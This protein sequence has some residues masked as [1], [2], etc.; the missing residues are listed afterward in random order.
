MSQKLLLRIASFICVLVL[1]A[2][3]NAQSIPI[4]SRW[5]RSFTASVAASPQTELAVELTSPTKKVLTVAGFWDGGTTWRV[6]FMP[7]ETGKWT[8]RT[9]SIPA[10]SGLDGQAGESTCSREA[11]KTRFL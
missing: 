6:R 10:V 11:G 4:W 9:R 3:A 7:S 5:E 8:F 1:T 2:S